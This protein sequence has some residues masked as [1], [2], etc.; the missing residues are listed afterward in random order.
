[1]FVHLHGCRLCYPVAEGPKVALGSRWSVP[2]PRLCQVSLLSPGTPA[3]LPA[4]CCTPSIHIWVDVGHG[5]TALGTLGWLFGC[6]QTR[7]PL[8]APSQPHCGHQGCFWC[9][10]QLSP[11]CLRS[12]WV[13]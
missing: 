4:L 3:E 1:M 7:A 13:L 9:Q 2:A 12:G 6:A 5:A 11:T 10:I 8:G